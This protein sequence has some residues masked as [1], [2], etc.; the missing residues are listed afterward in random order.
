VGGEGRELDATGWGMFRNLGVYCRI[1]RGSKRR[2]TEMETVLI[3]GN[4]PTL[5]FFDKCQPTGGGGMRPGGISRILARMDADALHGTASPCDD[6][7]WIRACAQGCGNVL[8]DFQSLAS[9]RRNSRFVRQTF[10]PLRR[11]CDG[12][13]SFIL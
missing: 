10:V 9:E 2:S 12:P 5:F 4:Y 1:M 8:S 6:V 13:A 7:I 11:A 3:C